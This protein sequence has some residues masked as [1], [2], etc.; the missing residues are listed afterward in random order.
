ME[1]ARFSGVGMNIARLQNSRQPLDGSKEM[2]IIPGFP[3]SKNHFDFLF[4]DW[5]LY[6]LMSSNRNLI[7]ERDN[8]DTDG[9]IDMTSRQQ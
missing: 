4:T 9:L 5:V 1:G 8:C 6:A 2:Q 3:V 7:L